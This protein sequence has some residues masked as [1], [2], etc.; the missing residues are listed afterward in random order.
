MLWC[1]WNWNVGFYWLL[2]CCR[3]LVAD[4]TCN[5]MSM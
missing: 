5:F 1:R 3:Y 4:I 2:I